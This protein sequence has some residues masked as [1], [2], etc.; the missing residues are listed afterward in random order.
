MMIVRFL[1]FH[2]FEHRKERL[3][4]LELEKKQLIRQIA[5][6]YRKTEE[7]KAQVLEV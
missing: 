3:H 7:E 4:E 2:R 5:E 6:D 1:T